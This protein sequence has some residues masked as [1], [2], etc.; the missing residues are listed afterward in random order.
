MAKYLVRFLLSLSILISSGYSAIYASVD[1]DN[2]IDGYEGS[3]ETVVG[4]NNTQQ[5]PL[6]FSASKEHGTS[7]FTVNN[8]KVEEEEKEDEF[9]TNHDFLDSAHFS[10]IFLT[11]IF[12]FL[13]QDFS[14]DLHFSKFIPN[15]GELRKHVVIQV[16]R[17]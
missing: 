13:F 16:F 10:A 5:H 15:T 8:S 9:V 17:I 14:H 4:I 11:R 7:I 1:T 3:F 6:S 12:G 2:A